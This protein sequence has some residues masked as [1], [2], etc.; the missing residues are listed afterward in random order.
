M[1]TH[2]QADI[3]IIGGGAGGLSV[4][5]G[6][7]QMGANVVLVEHKKMGG[8]CLNVGCVPSKSLLAAAKSAYQ[9]QQTEKFGVSTQ[10][11][12]INFSKVMQHVKSVIDAITHNDSVERFEGLGV[13]V[14]LSDAKFLN[15]NTL[16]A[17]EYEI[18]AKRFVIATG[19]SPFV[20]P[21]PGLKDIAFYTNETIFDLTEKPSHLIV[22]GGGPIG[23]ELAQAFLMLG[24]KVTVLEMFNIMPR[25]DGELV[26]IMRKN[27]I[28]QGL[29]I[30]ENIKI[31]EIQNINKMNG[32][33]E[34][35]IKIESQGEIK[36][37]SGSHVLVSAGRRP[38]VNQL[39]L[40]NAKVIYSPKGIQVDQYLRSSSNKKIYAIGDCAGSYQ[41]TH[42]AAY[43]AGIVIKNIL[44]KLFAKTDYSVVPWVTYTEPEL[45]QVGLIEKEA[46][47]KYKDCR[48]LSWTFE[49]ND[50]AQAEKE[51]LGKI[52]VIT[53]KKGYILGVSML[54]KNA[55]ELL[56]PW[57]I[58]MQNKLKISKMTD[59]IVPY[60]TLSEISKR[61]AGQFYTP[62]LFSDKMKKWVRLIQ[63]VFR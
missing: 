18:T 4:A 48:I 30:H 40:E 10:S 2:L 14:I 43:H 24:C 53:D 56:L 20:P 7:S 50:R 46:V 16:L 39:D 32:V 19:S 22:I 61:A 60:P 51:T 47:Q 36:T 12:E 58:L 21:I 27:F 11:V 44:F 23:C 38:N 6:A 59:C 8:D 3:A 42:I 57:I 45:A 5:A 34:K 35:V 28:S 13:K 63:R 62:L 29:E 15:Q 54:G 31:L 55:G 49:E 26:E 41:F 9:I 37:I 25:D 17:G 1:T 33:K 52:K